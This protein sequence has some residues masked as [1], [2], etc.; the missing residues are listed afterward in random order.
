MIGK[1]INQTRIHMELDEKAF[2]AIWGRYHYGDTDLILLKEI[3]GAYLSEH[4]VT[5]WF[6][7]EYDAEGNAAVLMTL[8]ECVDHIQ[9]Q[10]MEE[11]KMTEA[12][13]LECLAMTVLEQAY[14][15]LDMILHD[16]TGLWCVEYRFPGGEDMA[17]VADIVQRMEQTV[18]SCNEA[19]MLTPKKSVVYVAVM[20]AEAGK[21]N[22]SNK[23][24]AGCEKIKC[25]N[26]TEDGGIGKDKVALNYGY[27]RIFGRR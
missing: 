10:L 1:K 25:P 20:K 9:N 14:S 18:V 3:Y 5:V 11:G 23:V 8:G 19:Y 7:P 27:Q 17:C 15:K 26:R 2:R 13:M 24:C 12:Y 4:E 22:C 6:Q 21:E 16:E